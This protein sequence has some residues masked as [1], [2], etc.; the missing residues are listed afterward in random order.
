[1][2]DKSRVTALK[3]KKWHGTQPLLALFGPELMSDF[4]PQSAWIADMDQA[5][6]TN[7]NL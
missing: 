6:L 3:L 1:M 2:R 5:A 7:L 4:S